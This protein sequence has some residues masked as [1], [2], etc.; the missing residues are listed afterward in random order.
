MPPTPAK[1]H[2][3]PPVYTCEIRE[4][5]WDQL[6]DLLTALQIEMPNLVFATKD[7][8]TDLKINIKID[9]LKVLVMCLKRVFSYCI[10][11]RDSIQLTLFECNRYEVIHTELHLKWSNVAQGRCKH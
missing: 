5:D 7:D 6:A 2:C 8:P 1:G 10:L 9:V 11:A 4:M 3:G